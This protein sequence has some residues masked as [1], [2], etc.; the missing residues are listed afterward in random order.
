MYTQ[1]TIVLVGKRNS[2]KKKVENYLKTNG[3]QTK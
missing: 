1:P 2:T 3:I